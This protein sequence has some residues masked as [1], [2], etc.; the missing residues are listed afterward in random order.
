M[1]TRL[2]SFSIEGDRILS[3]LLTLLRLILGAFIAFI[4]VVMLIAGSSLDVLGE[5][6]F[7]APLVL[8]C[9]VGIILLAFLIVNPRYLQGQTPGK[10]SVHKS[11]FLVAG[12]LYIPIA[13]RGLMVME[14]INEECSQPLGCDMGGGVFGLFGLIV[15][16]VASAAAV[17][18]WIM[19]CNLQRQ[20]HGETQ[21]RIEANRSE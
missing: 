1:K 10:K 11:L 20:V 13:I 2:I 21:D 6:Q 19:A 17:S 4:A 16:L 8:C 9:S 15:A 14:H 12:A 7:F 3:L 18:Y 5:S